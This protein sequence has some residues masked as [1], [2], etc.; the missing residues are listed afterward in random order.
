MCLIVHILTG[1]QNPHMGCPPRAIIVGK[2]KRKPMKL[3][4][5]SNAKTKIKAIALHRGNGPGRTGKFVLPDPITLGP[6]F[7]EVLVSKAGKSHWEEGGK[8]QYFAKLKMM[9]YES[10]LLSTPQ[11][12]H[13]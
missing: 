5:S 12:P 4:P 11:A 9:Y 2:T 3:P 7:V 13:L 6:I 1:W 8:L 10:S